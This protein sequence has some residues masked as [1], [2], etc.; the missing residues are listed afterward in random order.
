MTAMSSFQGYSQEMKTAGLRDARAA[1]RQAKTFSKN[2]TRND[3][4]RPACL[5][6]FSAIAAALI[7]G[8]AG[9]T[10]YVRPLDMGLAREEAGVRARELD[11]IVKARSAAIR[12]AINSLELRQGLNSAALERLMTGFSRT[13]PDFLSLEIANN[14]GEVLAMI[15]DV[16]LAEAA[17]PTGPEIPGGRSIALAD[18]FGDDP[19]QD[20]FFVAQEERAPGG[21]RWLTRARFSRASIDKALTSAPNGQVAR[22]IRT[23]QEPRST[24]WGLTQA[25]SGIRA[26]WAGPV[27]AEVRLATPGWM[28]RLE[29]RTGVSLFSYLIAMVVGSIA[30]VASGLYLIPRIVPGLDWQSAPDEQVAEHNTE[31]ISSI[32][33]P[34][35]DHEAERQLELD[36]TRE[37]EARVIVRPDIVRGVVLSLSD[38]EDAGIQAGRIAPGQIASPDDCCAQPGTVPELL[39]ITWDELDNADHSAS[40]VGCA[41][42]Q[43]F[44]VP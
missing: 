11:A 27:V 16:P 38:V 8:L 24:L 5:C 10:A 18:A 20:S 29:R 36:F 6:L 19:A 34:D 7:V 37:G 32:R 21:E 35:R 26:L 43:R 22:L 12:M 15:G 41:K 25:V 40:Q 30:L 1:I 9:Y 4:L 42:S 28:V 39:E 17:R 33:M 13:F 44:A 3:L 23:S 31:V 2:W 14:Q